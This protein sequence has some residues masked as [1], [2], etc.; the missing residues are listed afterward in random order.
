MTKNRPHDTTV[1]F[2][3]ARQAMIDRGFLPEFSDEVRN[4]VASL[5]QDPPLDESSVDL[6]R[7][8]WCSIDNDDTR[9]IDQLT[10]AESDD[11]GG[12]RVWVGIADV[13]WLVELGSAI[14]RHAAHNTT[15]V[16]TPVHNFLMLPAELSTG[17]TSLNEGADR[18]GMVMEMVVDGEGAIVWE[19][20]YT[21]Q[22]RNH[23]KLAYD[24]VSEWLEGR[25]DA[26]DGVTGRPEIETSLR[27]QSEAATKLSKN[28]HKMGA[29]DLETIQPQAVI[30]SDEVTDLVE[31]P[32]NKGRLIIEDLMIA[33]NG[34]TTR[35]LE[36]KEFPTFRRV[37]RE[38]RRWDRIV[39]IADERGWQL[40]SE[41]DSG[42]LD[43]FLI[44][45]RERDRA[46]FP[47]LSLTIVKLIG[48]GEYAVEVPGGEKIG[49]FGLAVEDYS[50]STAPNRRYPDLITHRLLKAAM[51]GES[52]PYDVDTLHSLAQRCTEM[53]DEAKKVE[54]RV[55]KSASALLL[56]RMI[57]QQFEGIV[58]GASAKGTWVRVFRPPVE[59]KLVS[60][61]K[62]VDVG[63]RIQVKLTRVDVDRGFIDFE[64]L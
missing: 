26:L 32:Q 31:Q 25:I 53:E 42:A 38:P 3:L 40:P 10:H 44:S 12:I 64:R 16:Y 24:S 17:R 1:L 27:L 14:D 13:D 15:T 23:S 22:M 55:R 34:I 20:V 43:E 5:P 2:D 48:S 11:D 6:R 39:S 47:D 30:E 62:G 56:R 57:G 60:G 59:G 29:L 28:R 21:A 54:R 51:T 8:P 37:V 45:E 41:P 49:H 58:T 4:E 33:A 9:D 61:E 46:G 35:F 7:L 63:D 18:M 36:Q 19:S 50:H 52:S